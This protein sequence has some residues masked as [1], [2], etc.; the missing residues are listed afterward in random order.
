FLARMP[1]GTAL[2]IALDAFSFFIAAITPLFLQVPSPKRTDL[3]G[4]ANGRKT[5]LADIREGAMYIWVRRPMLWLLATF[6]MANLM[7]SFMTMLR[8]MMVKFNLA[9]EWSTRGFTYETA[10]ALVSSALGVGGLVGGLIISA[11]GGLKTRRVYGV[12][13]F[14]ILASF[15]QVVFGLANTLFVAAAASALWSGLVPFMNAHS[16]AIWQSQ[17]PRELQGRVFSVRRVIAQ[18]TFPI[19]T[20]LAGISGGLFNPGTV[21]AVAGVLLLIFCLGQLT[22]PSLLR[23]EDK[24]YMDELASQAAQ[25]APAVPV[26][27]THT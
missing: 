21:I 2:A 18:F 1:D 24:A 25:P 14:T 7:F 20:A 27:Q 4:G 5:V 26:E 11:W 8:P 23:I 19:G 6:T 10:L 17:T 15:A 22:N 16:A 3:G 13:L 9:A 12:I